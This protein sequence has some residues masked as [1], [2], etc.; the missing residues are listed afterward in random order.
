[1]NITSIICNRKG[2]EM[3]KNEIIKAINY[4][5]DEL[6]EEARMSDNAKESIGIHARAKTL[7]SALLIITNYY[8]GEEDEK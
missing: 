4:I 1:M 3:D 7:E 8:M 5:K 6:M 2:I